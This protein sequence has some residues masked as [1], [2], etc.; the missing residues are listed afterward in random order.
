MAD[1]TA[2]FGKEL[3]D[4]ASEAKDSIPDVARTA[5]RKVDEGR[6]MA[7]DRLEGVAS[8]SRNECAS[9]QVGNE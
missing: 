6:T 5:I 8:R 3:A 7:A 4:R 1:K 2:S 9:S